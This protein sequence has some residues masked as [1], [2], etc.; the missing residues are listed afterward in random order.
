[1]DP[2]LPLKI[3]AE[4]F[5]PGECG[6]AQD[7]TGTTP[8]TNTALLPPVATP[9]IGTQPEQNFDSPG[10]ASL[11]S[12]T[13]P[14]DAPSAPSSPQHKVT[15]A[16]EL[17]ET[18]EQ[19]YTPTGKQGM[20]SKFAAG[21]KLKG[22]SGKSNQKDQTATSP[23]SHSKEARSP[24]LGREPAKSPLPGLKGFKW[25]QKEG[26]Q[27]AG[28]NM[29]KAAMETSLPASPSTP[30][31]ADVPT[32]ILHKPNPPF[33]QTA[34]IPRKSSLASLAAIS[35]SQESLSPNL[36]NVYSVSL[37]STSPSNIGSPHLPDGEYPSPPTH[38]SLPS[39]PPR[40]VR[41]PSFMPAYPPQFIM[42]EDHRSEATP[43][44]MR[45]VSSGTQRAFGVASPQLLPQPSMAASM[46]LPVL[47]DS[48][49]HATG[50]H[51]PQR[52]PEISGDSNGVFLGHEG[53]GE[54]HTT[55]AP[56]TP[57][58]AM[59]S[60][61]PSSGR[62]GKPLKANPAKTK[63]RMSADS[64]LSTMMKHMQAIES[65]EENAPAADLGHHHPA[66]KAPTRGTFGLGLGLPGI[67][68]ATR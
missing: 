17:Q 1:M 23:H 56:V 33:A 29:Q 52:T 25:W 62:Y 7:H 4:R 47:S 11:A 64:D 49:S 68:K 59:P 45:N 50:D 53:Q 57:S 67:R 16:P 42:D 34:R 9:T 60:L 58:S 51:Y 26:P 38:T 61:V 6:Q 31:Q 43:P 13:I 41:L 30:Q 21:L 22:W 20:S 10:G 19:P 55:S 5:V 2:P 24:D 39:P 15:F 14:Y 44:L 12:T 66:R 54:G 37:P 36:Q 3:R 32:S 48:L 40:P 28:D 27:H 18:Q 8:T 63:F 65:G 35:R 46:S